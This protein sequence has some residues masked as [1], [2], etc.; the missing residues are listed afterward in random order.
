MRDSSFVSTRVLSGSAARVLRNAY[1]LLALTL[2]PTAIGAWIGMIISW[3]FFM[4][5]PIFGSILLM[6]SLFGLSYAIQRNSNSVLG[7]YLLFALTFVM[8]ITLGPLLTVALSLRNGPML[9][10]YAAAAT[11][12][13]LFGLSA[14]ITSTGKDLS[15]MS[16]FMFV[17]A[18]VLMISIF[19]N[20]FLNIPVFSLVITSLIAVF[21]V[22]SIAYSLSAAVNGGES[23]YILL[24]TS[25]YVNLFNLF[26]S[27]LRL[28][29]SFSGQRD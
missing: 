3:Q 23:N 8:G 25:L 14:W 24:A 19:A 18:I 17:G 7:V 11:A 16:R 12:L 13:T 9:I 26:V 1:V 4:Q 15:F 27:L 28:L 5:S 21:S 2:I 10:S 6:A 22:M 20:L 29:I